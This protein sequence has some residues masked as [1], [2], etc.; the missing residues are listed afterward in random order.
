GKYLIAILKAK[1]TEG[2]HNYFESIPLNAGPESRGAVVGMRYVSKNTNNVMSPKG[3]KVMR[4][5]KEEPLKAQNHAYRLAWTDAERTAIQQT[6]WG[7]D[8][9]QILSGNML[10]T[11][12]TARTLGDVEVA[13]T[14]LTDNPWFNVERPKTSDDG[15]TVRV[16]TTRLSSKAAREQG[17]DLWV[18]VDD[19][20]RSEV[21]KTV[22]AVAERI[23]ADEIQA[24]TQP[25]SKAVLGSDQ[26]GTIVVYEEA[27]N[28]L[29]IARQIELL[30]RQLGVAGSGIT[31]SLVSTSG[32]SEQEIIKGVLEDSSGAVDLSGSFKTA[33][34]AGKGVDVSDPKAVRQELESNRNLPVLEL[35]A[36][37]DVV[38][39]YKVAEVK[40]YAALVSRNPAKGEE[41]IA[42]GAQ[43]VLEMVELFGLDA[44]ARDR[45]LAES[46]KDFT[47]A[48]QEVG[49][50]LED[51][52][53]FYRAN[54]GA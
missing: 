18:E 4:D 37:E 52:D 12:A 36:P 40:L 15:D 45:L 44:G 28:N 50:Q 24:F 48:V 1:S 22:E 25:L 29:T 32:A 53:N 46:M 31:F 20:R 3:D 47:V 27:L 41:G 9:D 23:M 10:Y 34:I 11:Q 54:R 39:A 17:A 16:A 5:A 8:S 14:H 49:Q 19:V 42:N 38:S 7:R 51:F 33:V 13:V 35:I 2:T 43:A 26:T 6:R 21:M 30:A